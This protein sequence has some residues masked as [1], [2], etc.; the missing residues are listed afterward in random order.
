MKIEL[1]LLDVIQSQIILQEKNYQKALS[2]EAS[3]F[4]LKLIEDEI[5][6]L[7]HKLSY[8]KKN[9]SKD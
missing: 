4:E 5:E 9:F 3:F 7:K 1:T 6:D 8:V 2:K